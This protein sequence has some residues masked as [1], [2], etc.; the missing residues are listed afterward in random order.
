MY[1]NVRLVKNTAEKIESVR[2]IKNT[3][4]RID[5]L[6]WK[7]LVGVEESVRTSVAVQHLQKAKD[8]LDIEAERRR[9]HLG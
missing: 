5:K 8:L 1:K 4:E 9:C 3:A 6:T 7:L 2:L